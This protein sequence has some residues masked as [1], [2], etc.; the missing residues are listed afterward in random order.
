MHKTS[1]K[2][3]AKGGLIPKHFFHFGSYLQKWVPKLSPEDLFFT[4]DSGLRN[5]RRAG[6]KHKTWK[7]REKGT[8]KCGKKEKCRASTNKNLILV[9]LPCLSEQTYVA[10]AN[11]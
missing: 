8:K 4:V 9:E 1:S 5:R 6:K 2:A 3:D 11:T 7:I 10:K